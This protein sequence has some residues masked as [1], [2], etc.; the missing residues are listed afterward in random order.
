MKTPALALFLIATLTG[1]A[2]AQGPMGGQRRAP[3]DHWLTIDSLVAA[4]GITDAQKPD[5]TKHYD[6][7]NAIMKQAAHERQEMFASMG[8]ERPSADQMQAFRTKLESMQ[9]DLDKHLKE[10]RDLLT[11]EQQAKLDALP[12]PRVAFQRRPQ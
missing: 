2:Q 5:V 12:Q 11:P 4:V 10:L 9:V 3:P 1:A 7:V 8:G 6:A